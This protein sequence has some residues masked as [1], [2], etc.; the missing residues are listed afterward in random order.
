MICWYTAEL[1]LSHVE[2]TQ[3]PLLALIVQGRGKPGS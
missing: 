3:E 1:E 2:Q